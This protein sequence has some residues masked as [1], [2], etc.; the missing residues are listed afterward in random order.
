MILHNNISVE[1]WVVTESETAGVIEKLQEASKKQT[2]VQWRKIQ[3]KYLRGEE[4]WDSSRGNTVTIWRYL[5]VTTFA[6]IWTKETIEFN[7]WTTISIV[8]WTRINIGKRCT[9][10]YD[11]N[12]KKSQNIKKVKMCQMWLTVYS[13]RRTRN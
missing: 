4:I 1:D 9:N 7:T 6:T 10:T 3:K 2:K 11:N 5:W 12:W 13:W 8:D